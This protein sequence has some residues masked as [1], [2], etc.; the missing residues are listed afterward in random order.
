MTINTQWVLYPCYG[1]RSNNGRTMAH[2]SLRV[3]QFLLENVTCERACETCL[4][5]GAPRQ[6]A[7]IV[8]RWICGRHSL[9]HVAG[10]DWMGNNHPAHGNRHAMTVMQ[11]NLALKQF[12]KLLCGFLLQKYIPKEISSFFFRGSAISKQRASSLWASYKSPQPPPPCSS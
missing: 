5:R 4:L 6:H 2:M 12:Q 9:L 8:S 3:A 10:M 1:I 7:A 11:Q